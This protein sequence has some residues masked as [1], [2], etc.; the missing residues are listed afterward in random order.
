MAT[1]E[2]PPIAT[3]ECEKCNAV[4]QHQL[5]AAFGGRQFWR[6]VVCGTTQPTDEE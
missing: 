5:Q 6:C 2:K 1:P 3:R 4:T